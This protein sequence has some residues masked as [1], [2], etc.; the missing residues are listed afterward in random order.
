MF[1][2]TRR[3]IVDASRALFIYVVSLFGNESGAIRGTFYDAHALGRRL[4]IR[5]VRAPFAKIFSLGR[6]RNIVAATMTKHGRVGLVTPS[7]LRRSFLHDKTP[8]PRRIAEFRVTSR[9]FRMFLLTGEICRVSGDLL[10][11]DIAKTSRLGQ[12]TFVGDRF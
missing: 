11:R 3:Y 10:R 1:F 9:S 6:F 4:L 8:V 2:L 12:S 5:A 7:W